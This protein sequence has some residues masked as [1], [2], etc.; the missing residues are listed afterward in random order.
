M[1]IGRKIRDEVFNADPHRQLGLLRETVWAIAVLTDL[2]EGATEEDITKAK[3]IMVEAL[4]VHTEIEKRL[5]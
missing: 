4:R 1:T 3:A 5:N 2:V